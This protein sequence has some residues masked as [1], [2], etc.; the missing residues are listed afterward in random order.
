MSDDQSKLDVWAVVELFGHQRIAGHITE[1]SIAGGAFLRV[2]VPAQGGCKER[3]RYGFG[4]T[5]AIPEYTRYFGAGAIYAMTPC[6]EQVARRAA[7][8]FRSTPPIP[9]DVPDIVQRPQLEGPD[10]FVFD[11]SDE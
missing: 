6:T 10:T 7:A 4:P 2:D 1:V 3:D 8:E 11:D 9:F 5:A